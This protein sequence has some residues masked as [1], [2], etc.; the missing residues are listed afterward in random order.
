LTYIL[1]QEEIPYAS[2]MVSKVLGAGKCDKVNNCKAHRSKHEANKIRLC[3]KVNTTLCRANKTKN[4]ANK[5][6]LCE[7]VNTTL[8]KAHKMKH[9]AKQGHT[10]C[11]R[12]TTTLCRKET[13]AGCVWNFADPQTLIQNPFLL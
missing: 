11:E 6:R 10:V 12:R 1:E 2:H 7:K 5:S 8:C 9:E 13:R 3:E 4:E